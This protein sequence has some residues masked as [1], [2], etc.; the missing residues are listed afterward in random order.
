MGAVVLEKEDAPA[1][2]LAAKVATVMHHQRLRA[3]EVS[4]TGRLLDKCWKHEH[5]LIGKA[6]DD[7]PPAPPR[8]VAHEDHSRCLQ[9]GIALCTP[10]GKLLWKKRNRL[11]DVLKAECPRGSPL[12]RRLLRQGNVV[13][14]LEPSLDREGGDQVLDDWGIDIMYWH[15]SDLMLNPYEPWFQECHELHSAEEEAWAAVGLGELGLKVTD[16]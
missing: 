15:V 14:N 3:A 4:Q 16:P 5:R 2:D 1:N 6:S 13:F 11:L 12:K 7:P 10:E 9:Y 8:C